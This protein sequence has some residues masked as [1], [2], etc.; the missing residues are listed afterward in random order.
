MNPVRDR[1]VERLRAVTADDKVRLSHALWIEAR[2]VA[3]AGVRGR[4]PD[5]TDEQVATNRSSNEPR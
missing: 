3:A 4:H 1:Q 5:W 2:D